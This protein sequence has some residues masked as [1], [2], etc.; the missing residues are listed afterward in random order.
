MGRRSAAQPTATGRAWHRCVPYN[1][2]LRGSAWRVD[3]SM[4]STDSTDSRIHRAQLYSDRMVPTANLTSYNR[5]DAA[6]K[7]IPQTMPSAMTA[8]YSACQFGSENLP[9]VT[10]FGLTAHP[11]ACNATPDYW[12]YGNGRAVRPTQQLP[13]AGIYEL[14]LPGY[15]RC[16]VHPIYNGLHAVVH[17]VRTHRTADYAFV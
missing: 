16:G 5:R 6:H 11:S 13:P 15:A 9:R 2:R 3:T 10:R 17:T 1:R 8:T 7:R 4:P 14:V 12:V